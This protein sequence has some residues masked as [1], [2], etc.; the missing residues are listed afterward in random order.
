[1]RFAYDYAQ[2]RNLFTCDTFAAGRAA[3]GLRG[4]ANARPRRRRLAENL[5][6]PASTVNNLA[7]SFPAPR[8]VP[9]AAQDYPGRNEP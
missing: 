6:L 9:S 3:A 5:D 2:C 8:R 4:C 1:V 7:V